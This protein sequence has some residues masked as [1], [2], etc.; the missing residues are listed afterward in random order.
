MYQITPAG[1]A[2]A[3]EYLEKNGDLTYGKPEQPEPKY[4]FFPQNEPEVLEPWKNGKQ[5]V[6][7]PKEEEKAEEPELVEAVALTWKERDLTEQPD[8]FWRD[9]FVELTFKLVDKL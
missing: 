4:R 5:P 1:R 8:T 7:K 2:M 3:N 9:K 6:S